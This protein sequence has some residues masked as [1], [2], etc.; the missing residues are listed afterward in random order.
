MK[1]RVIL[2]TAVAAAAFGGARA[3]QNHLRS[4]VVSVGRDMPRG[5][6]VCYS[7]RDEALAGG[8]APSLYLQPLTAWKSSGQGSEAAFKRPFAWVDREVFVHVGGATAAYDLYVNDTHA[9]YNECGTVPADFNITALAKEGANTL[10]VELHADAATRALENG[11]DPREASLPG[12]VYIFSQPKVRVRDVVDDSRWEEGHGLLSFGA[13]IKSHLLNVKTY[14]VYYELLSPE[15]EIVAR[16]NRD[17][18]LDMQR[19]DTLRFF[20]NIPDIVPW[21]HETPYLYTLMIKTQHEGR[22]KEYL[23][24]PVGFKTMEFDGGRMKING[25]ETPLYAAEYSCPDLAALRQPGDTLPDRELLVREMSRLR[26]TG[27]NTLKVKGHTQPDVFYDVCDELGFYVIDQAD[28]DTHLAGEKITR[29][30]NPSN[31]PRWEEIY[32]DRVLSAYHRTK[33]HPSTIALSLA[34][35]SANGYCLYEGYLALKRC[36]RRRPVIYREAR[37]EWNSDPLELLPAAGAPKAAAG[38]R[39]TLSGGGKGEFRVANEMIYT[40]FCGELA[41]KVKSMG[42]VVASGTCSV[43]VAPGAQSVVSVPLEAVKDGRS[44]TVAV[45]LLA[46]AGGTRYR[47]GADV[48]RRVTLSEMEVKVDGKR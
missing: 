24:L 7:T 39:V 42:K 31:D 17:I 12:P 37:G 13:V 44:C 8:L 9:G 20:S 14:R 35:N 27:V 22:F 3:Q 19:E 5:N 4:D 10:R 23:A 1:L 26:E 30:G 28:I 47:H 40:P 18:N 25:I 46:P 38:K 15:G 43:R 45:E 33:S 32:V 36:E 29:G 41:Y 48:S 16:G 2:A 34:E 6:I 11:R 21:T